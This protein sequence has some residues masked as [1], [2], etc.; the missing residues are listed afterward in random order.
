M[1]D[2]E[3]ILQLGIEAARAGDKAEARE[4]FRLV[5]REDPRNA[6]GWLWLA[7]VAEDRGEK[8]AALEHV[9]D[10]D[11]NNELARKGLNALIGR[12]GGAGTAAAAPIA[13]DAG[14]G[15]AAA[16]AAATAPR[17]SGAR[18][19]EST[20]AAGAGGGAPDETRTAPAFDDS[21]YDL[22][23][24]RATPR[25][26]ASDFDAGDTR[27]VVEDE[28]PRRRGGMS[29]LPVLLSIGAVLLAGLFFFNQCRND[30]GGIVSDPGAAVGLGTTST[31]EGVGVA[32]G[33]TDPITG[34]EAVTGS[35]P[36]TDTTAVTDTG[37]VTS[38]LTDT[39]AINTTIPLTGTDGTGQPAPPAAEATSELAPPAPAVT[40]EPA[41]AVVETAPPVVET[42]P[43]PAEQTPAPPEQPAP[44]AEQTAAPT[45]GQTTVVVVPPEAT[46]VPPPA[47]PA[48]AP[49]P[50]APAP[51]P[52]PPAAPVDVAAA[53]PA[54]VPDGT[55]VPAGP[56]RFTSTQFKNI[57]TGSYGGAPPTRGQYQIVVLAVANGSD[58]PAT[59]P[60]GFFVL[61]DAQGRVYDFNRAASVD[62]LNRFGGPGVAAD[63]GADTPVPN[64]NSLT[65]VPL[66]F[67]VPP[68]ATNL[69][70][71]SR[72]NP[73]QGFAIR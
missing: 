63:I 24:Y 70:L 13:A 56:W 35:A 8:R 17:R 42:A 43:P 60:D 38:P 45:T 52:P 22:A 40:S 31:A 47:A 58:Q 37:A 36:L 1:A 55:E 33:A 25:G 62:Y 7:G 15:E 72:D 48:P 34:T 53:N 10:I 44:P 28:E 19:Y 46:V 68:D 41:P 2:T 21:D 73:N 20:P 67:D 32:G 9:I 26:D 30:D 65:S 64:N 11:P 16:A 50:A 29:W 3:S 54:I 4:L 49:P 39:G 66:L 12:A 27:V 51:A 59:I 61:K 57:A 6:Q 5:T 69:V 18:Q 14:P 71:F 23:E